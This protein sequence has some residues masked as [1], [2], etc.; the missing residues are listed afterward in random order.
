[1]RQK[2]IAFFTALCLFLAAVE[3][4]IPKP[5]PFLRLGLANLPIILSLAKMRRRDT[6]LLILCKVLGQGIITGTL[7][8]Y[9]FLFSAAGSLSSG[10]VMLALHSLC[11][12]HISAAGLSLA[13]ALANNAAQLVLARFIL[14][15]TNVRFIAP[16]L[17][18]TGFVTGLLLGI[19]AEQFMR[20]S[21]WY[22]SLPPHGAGEVGA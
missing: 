8:S 4:A 12:R 6:L 19:F 21:R 14:F 1:M 3:Y 22:A 15:G 16:V 17:L 18:V 9:V 13:G 2:Q 7:F 10:L 11:G 20:K 5:L